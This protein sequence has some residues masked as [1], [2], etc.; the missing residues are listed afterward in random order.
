MNEKCVSE[1]VR[2]APKHLAI[3]TMIW[4][5]PIQ[6]YPTVTISDLHSQTKSCMII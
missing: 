5:L 2:S 3:E 1:R 4:D 6:I